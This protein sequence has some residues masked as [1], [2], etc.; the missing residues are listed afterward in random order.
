MLA[1]ASKYW[2][3]KLQKILSLSC[4]IYHEDAGELFFLLETMQK[5]ES[6]FLKN[7]EYCHFLQA[8]IFGNPQKYH[9]YKPMKLKKAT[10]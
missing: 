7:S 1:N 10:S 9:R 5:L 3:I 2:S 4:F 6:E 8:G